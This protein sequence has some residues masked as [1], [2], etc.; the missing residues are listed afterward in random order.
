MMML[1]A[2][3]PE[4]T[5]PGE[6]YVEARSSRGV[7]LRLSGVEIDITGEGLADERLD[8]FI[9]R[10]V[11]PALVALQNKIHGERQ[12]SIAALREAAETG[13]PE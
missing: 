6:I 2:I 7:P 4:A 5:L 9:V 13:D 8:A 10:N 11:F 1:I 12:Q 3:C